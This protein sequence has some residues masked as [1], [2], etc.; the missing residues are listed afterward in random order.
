MRRIE[1]LIDSATLLCYRFATVATVAS[2]AAAP[3]R[4]EPAARAADARRPTPD[5]MQFVSKLSPEQWAE[6][7]RLRAEGT[8]FV[9]IAHRFGVRPATVSARARREGWHAPGQAAS[10]A[11]RPGA[12]A[13]DAATCGIRGRLALRLYTVIEFRIRMME[14]RMQKQLQGY[15]NDPDGSIPPAPTKD[16]R[17]SFAALIDSIDKVTEMASAPAPAANGRRKSAI[18]VNPELAALGDDVDP[19]G[20]AVASEKDALRREIAERLE[21]IFPPS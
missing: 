17:D 3:R 10:S 20:L 9:E 7:R 18:P 15:E 11:R 6:A 12:V 2:M 1:I 13:A 19:D 16:E 14:L 5:P 4:S 21:K 8:P